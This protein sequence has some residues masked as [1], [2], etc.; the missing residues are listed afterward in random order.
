MGAIVLGLIFLSLMVWYLQWSWLNGEQEAHRTANQ[1]ALS[2]A[3]SGLNAAMQRLKSPE[4]SAPTDDIVTG[5]GTLTDGRYEYSLAFDTTTTNLVDAWAT[6][7]Y[8]LPK[9]SQRDPATGESAQRAVLHAKIFSGSITTFLIAVPGRLRV[10]DGITAAGAPI[11]ARDLVFVKGPDPA[12]VH[13]T[14]AFFARSARDDSGADSPAPAFAVFQSSPPAAQMLAY[15]PHFP[16]PGLGLRG[17]YQ[18]HATDVTTLTDGSDLSGA[19]PR[20]GDPSRPVYFV[21]G[22][23]SIGG[24]QA[25]VADD[26]VLIYA[27]GQI[28]IHNAILHQGSGWAAILAEKDVHLASDCP[29]PLAVQAT[30]LTS[31]AFRADGPARFPGRFLFQ[32]QM[33]AGGGIDLAGA[34]PVR[35]Y[36]WNVGTTFDLPAFTELLQYD[37]VE[38]KYR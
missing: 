13:L 26:A 36:F 18:S 5:S 8:H 3:D 27:T 11:Y 22:D 31:G 35:G 21:D 19:V 24:S 29:D 1:R 23:L 15:A 37:V 25:L 33:I 30:F 9:G 7:Y 34:W 6:G 28:R 32:G 10:N 16:R 38:G 20:E 14:S 12:R 2:Y 4:D 17:Y